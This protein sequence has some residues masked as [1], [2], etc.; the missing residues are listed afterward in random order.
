MKELIFEIFKAGKWT[1]SN[2][3]TRSYS[4]DDLDK[5]ANNYNPDVEEAPITLGHPFLGN[6]PAHGWIEEVF[7]VGNTLYARAKDLT[8]EFIQLLKEKKYKK[9]SI[10]LDRN[11]NL[12]HVAFLGAANPAVKGLADVFFE[13]EHDTFD[14]DYHDNEFF[15]NDSDIIQSTDKSNIS[16]DNSDEFFEQ[17]NNF[18]KTESKNEPEHTKNN[19]QPVNS[20][21][22]PISSNVISLDEKSIK[23]IFDSLSTLLSDRKPDNIE[24]TPKKTENNFKNHE[25]DFKFAIY[26]IRDFLTY[27]ND[28]VKTGN[29]APFF[30][31]HLSTLLTYLSDLRL[32]SAEQFSYFISCLKN[33]IDSFP[34]LFNFN[35][36]IP[37][38]HKNQRNDDFKGFNLDQDSYAQHKQILNIMASEGISYTEAFHKLFNS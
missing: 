16:A 37:I 14:F 19:N 10:G 27:V 12:K 17:N 3:F 28:K 20:P 30:V 33:F 31:N 11:F 38:P 5:I 36:N 2:G 25:S 32:L 4:T 13:E 18:S 22:N 24:Q 26:I 23:Q 6:E 34:L 29:A 9:R 15:H 1:S 21:L 35:E 8:D 7:R